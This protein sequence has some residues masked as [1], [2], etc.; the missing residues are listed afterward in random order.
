[1]DTKFLKILDNSFYFKKV[2]ISNYSKKYYNGSLKI[3]NEILIFTNKIRD[4]LNDKFAGKINTNLNKLIYINRENNLAGYNRFIINND[5][6][7]N[8][9]NKS[10]EIIS[11]EKMSLEEKYISILN[12]KIV[13]SPVG[14]NLVNFFFSK[15]DTIQLFILL[16]PEVDESY[17][18]F[19]MQ[20]LIELGNIN[21]N[22]IVRLNC[23]IID[24][25][26]SHDPVNKPYVV[27][28]TVL[29]SIIDKYL[30]YI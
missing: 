1:M 28:I 22:V 15:N 13:I 12:S 24:N 9:V 6:V 30:G 25:N 20:Q 26:V 23:K 27:D 4:Y 29:N 5:E 19:N 16:C 11:F 2:F 10:F 17:V 3:S 18:N 14:A 7:I 8:Y 21:P